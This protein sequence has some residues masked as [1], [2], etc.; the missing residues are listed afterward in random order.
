[1]MMMPNR[2]GTGPR[3]GRG[4]G[5]GGGQGRGQKCAGGGL[6]NG[7]GQGMGAGRGQGMGA[8]RGMRG[9]GNVSAKDEVVLSDVGTLT[10]VSAQGEG[11]DAAVDARFGRAAGFVLVNGSGEAVGY[12]DNLSADALGH[13]AGLASAE[14]VARAGAKILLT[15]RVGPKA[16]AALAAAGVR[17]VEGCDGLSVGEAVKR[18]EQA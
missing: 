13:G 11:L 10:A 14:A 16:A 3:M 12:I 1:M 2:D 9:V 18:I 15:G 17:V 5:F 4:Q 6:G 8:G 7:R